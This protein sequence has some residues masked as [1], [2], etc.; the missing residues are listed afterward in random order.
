MCAQV[1][2]SGDYLRGHGWVRLMRL[3]CALIFTC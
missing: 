2:P 3:L 1:T